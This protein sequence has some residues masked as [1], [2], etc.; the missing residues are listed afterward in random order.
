M[1]QAIEELSSDLEKAQDAKKNVGFL[2]EKQS[3]LTAETEHLKTE[4]LASA[5]TLETVKQKLESEVES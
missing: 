4:P 1:K 2:S 3:E 5:A